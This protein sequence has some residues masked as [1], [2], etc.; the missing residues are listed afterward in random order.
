VHRQGEVSGLHVARV[1]G[2]E[3]VVFEH[4]WT[5]GLVQ[6]VLKV[7]SVV[8]AVETGP[9]PAVRI[10][11]RRGLFRRPRR[12][13]L[14]VEHEPFVHRFSV[15]T[16]DEDFAILLL[17]PE[18]QAW[19]AEGPRAAWEIVPGCVAMIRPG[20]LR[21]SDDDVEAGL[22]GLESFLEHVPDELA[23]WGT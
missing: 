3:A 16:D 1:D 17:T 2:R 21:E 13:E 12:G 18:L 8:S 15:R 5:V 23:Y 22:H 4:S 20:R 11:P 9:W 10:R 6:A 7:R 19:L 14:L